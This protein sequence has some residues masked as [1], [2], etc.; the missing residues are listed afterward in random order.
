MV[1]Q[2]VSFIILMIFLMFALVFLLFAFWIWMI[3]DCAKRKFKNDNEK[4]VWILV[5]IFLSLL[6]AVIYYFAIKIQDKGKV[7][8]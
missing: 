7:K 2:A 8:K 1:T 3:V 6:G 5:L 4:I